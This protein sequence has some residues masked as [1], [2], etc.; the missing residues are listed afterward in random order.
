M[1]HRSVFRLIDWLVDWLASH[2][3][4]TINRCLCR[5]YSQQ[6]VE[7]CPFRCSRPCMPWNCSLIF[8]DYPRKP[9]SPR[10]LS[11]GKSRG[12]RKEKSAETT[13]PPPLLPCGVDGCTFSTIYTRVL[14][15][16]RRNSHVVPGKIARVGVKSLR[17][18]TIDR[19]NQSI[20]RTNQSI[21]Q[22][23]VSQSISRYSQRT[24]LIYKMLV[25]VWT[26]QRKHTNLWQ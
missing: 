1:Q 19:S 4:Q 26:F 13:G 6:F 2:L 23:F 17:N 21:N 14:S 5:Y 12:S 15:N 9:E 10:K 22:S 25:P 11:T 7:L 16:H 8:L 18:I 3:N 24:S 20:D